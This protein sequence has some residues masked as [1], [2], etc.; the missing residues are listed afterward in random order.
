MPRLPCHHVPLFSV[1]QQGVHYGVVPGEPYAGSPSLWVA[2]RPH[3]WR[4]ATSKEHLL[5][6]DA[7]TGGVG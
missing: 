1:P 3:N 7:N 2:V 5:R 4:P 6:L